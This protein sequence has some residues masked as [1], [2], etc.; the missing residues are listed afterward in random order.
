MGPSFCNKDMPFNFEAIKRL[1][2]DLNKF[3]PNLYENTA[4]D[5]FW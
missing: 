2:S 3:W 4:Y 1:E 5:S